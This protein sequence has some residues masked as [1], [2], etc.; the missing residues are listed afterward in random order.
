MS[1]KLKFFSSEDEQPA[2][3]A[4]PHPTRRPAQAVP[5]AGTFFLDPQL[6]RQ[7]A[8]SQSGSV[9]FNGRRTG[10]QRHLLAEIS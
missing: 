2:F 9:H 5:A 1:V 4:V 3:V 10:Y 6:E 8:Q 7:S